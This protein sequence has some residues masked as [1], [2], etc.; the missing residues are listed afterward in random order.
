MVKMKFSQFWVIPLRAVQAPGFPNRNICEGDVG[1]TLSAY[2]RSRD[3]Y[4]SDRLP[5][6]VNSS[7][8][9]YNAYP[10]T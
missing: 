3:R 6:P 2:N 10:P 9:F 1:V 8:F 7:F 5:T 4:T